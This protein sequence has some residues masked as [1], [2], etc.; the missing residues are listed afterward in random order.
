MHIRRVVSL[1]CI[2]ALACFSFAFAQSSFI[3]DPT[4]VGAVLSFPE[5]CRGDQ[6]DNIHAFKTEYGPLYSAL[7][8]VRK[9]R[10]NTATMTLLNIHQQTIDSFDVTSMFAEDIVE[11]LS[12]Y[13]I[14]FWTPKPVYQKEFIPT[15]KCVAWRQTKGCDVSAEAVR[16]KEKDEDCHTILARDRSGF[17]E[18]VGGKKV[19]L[20]CGR[21]D[22]VSCESQ[23]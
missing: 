9:E 5:G 22:F 20:A 17:C 12:S 2:I 3:I 10:S 7:E 8:I 11:R 4:P 21:T 19:P 18:C 14:M 15:A 6:F 1:L 16:E 13:G 23:C